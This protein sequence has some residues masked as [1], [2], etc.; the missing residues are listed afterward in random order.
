MDTSL[1]QSLVPLGIVLFFGLFIPQ[2]LYRLRLPSTTSLIL[3]GAIMGPYGMNYLEVDKTLKLLAFMGAA[4]HM[5][6]AGF[7]SEKLHLGKDGKRLWLLFVVNGLIPGVSGTLLVNYF[8]Y[9][10]PTSALMGAIFLSSSI[11][12]TFSYTRHLRI[13]GTRLGNTLRSLVVI[14]DLVSTLVIFLVFQSVAPSGRFPLPVHLGLLLCSIILLRMFLPEVVTFFFQMLEAHEDNKEGKLRLLLALL[15][16][17]IIAYSAAGVHAVVGAFLVGF[18]LAGVP[19][20]EP[21]REKLRVLG[22]GIFVPVFLFVMG[23]ELNFKTIMELPETGWMI[24]IIALS[25]I[26]IKLMSGFIGGI[27]L[28][29]GKIDSMNLGLSTSAKLT[30]SLS[31]VFAAYESRLVDERLFTAAVLI[32]LLSSLAVPVA[33]NGLKYLRKGT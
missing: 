7:E 20:V 24:L 29:F 15:I 32:T 17:T 23:T 11:M 19:H 18:S 28:G 27:L 30:V 12:L 14:E 31:A 33:L 6:L 16:G 8:G 3:A 1:E 5:L 10:W 21:V 9:N 13:V 2:L 25:A 26:F 4:F 22:N